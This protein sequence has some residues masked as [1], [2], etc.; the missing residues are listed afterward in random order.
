MARGDLEAQI[1]RM[2]DQLR[3]RGAN[4]AVESGRQAVDEATGPF[5]KR[6]VIVVEQDRF[7]V[8][9]RLVLRYYG[10]LLDHLFAPAREEKHRAELAP[11][12]D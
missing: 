4:L 11:E 10:H 9:N 2:L 6:G 5:E 1:D 7:R 8:R 12:Q 3:A